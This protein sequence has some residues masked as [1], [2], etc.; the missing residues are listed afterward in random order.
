MIRLP[1][2]KTIL[3]VVFFIALIMSLFAQK[4]YPQNYFISPLDIPLHLSGTF[5]ELR[6]DHFHSGIDIRTGEVEGLKIYAVADGYISRIKVSSGGYGK[7][8]YIT[9]P[10]GYVS[11]YA[12]LRQYE[13]AIKD[14]VKSEQYR[15]ES[16][17]VDLYPQAGILQ[18]KRGEIIALSG[19]SGGSGGPHLHFEIRDAGSE[20]PINPLLFGYS[21]E[22]ITP[23]VINLIKVYPADLN[24][25]IRNKNKQAEFAV[26][27]SDGKYSLTGQDTILITGK[28]CFGINTIDL[29]NNGNNKNGVY[30][31]ALFVDSSQ[32]FEQVMETFSFDETRYVNSLIDFPDYIL[33]QRR[34]QKSFIQPNNHLSI[35]KNVKNDGIIEFTDD[36]IHQLTYK[37]ADAA[38]N[39][40]LL[41]FWM[42]SKVR[43]EADSYENYKSVSQ[44]I[45]FTYK[46]DNL[47]ETDQIKFEVPGTALYD[48]LLFNYK[49]LPPIKNSY[50]EIHQ[51][52]YPTSP[53]HARCNLFIKPDS[54]P[55]ELQDKAIIVK[56]DEQQKQIYVGGNWD[57]GFVNAQ[58][59]EF[60]KYCVMVDTVLPKIIP[61]NISN[62]KNITTQST[63][64]VKITDELSGIGSY[65]GQM[66]GKWILMDY[67]AK[68]DLL[69]YIYDERLSKGENIFELTV[70]DKKFNVSSYK[71]KLIY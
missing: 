3:S 61:V 68:N 53:L 1:F 66:N 71:T 25:L 57:N 41:S 6:T 40:S 16:F 31:I 45:F 69:T 13:G 10:N 7:A 50:S 5:G 63:I 42:K 59:R 47:F 38:G 8:I 24:C 56:I 18:V 60:G 44:G 26:Q 15:H 30:S 64:Q 17:E 55:H 39:V 51:L 49:F 21:V 29:F 62:N 4:K 12:H 22:D 34:V 37:V 70:T 2:L 9:H 11:V 33:I 54:I 35:Y 28:A 36:G 58:I 67:D 48:T 65:R 46:N 32:V 27:G 20:K 19:D 52:H 14:Y 23:P 43:N